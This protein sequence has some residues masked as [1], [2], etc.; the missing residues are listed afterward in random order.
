MDRMH[1]TRH[2]F[3]VDVEEWYHPLRFYRDTAAVETRRLRTGL[4]RITALLDERGV[5]GTFFWVADTA[6]AYPE[7]VR[8]L[9]DAGHETGCHSFAH[10][11]MVYDQTPEDF[12]A[13]TAR[14][15]DVLQDLTGQPVRAYRAPCFSVTSAS[16]WALDVLAELGV[17]LDSSVFPVKNWR[18][19]I[20]DHPRHPVTA[21]GGRLWEAPLSARTVG[22]FTFP[23]AG[24]AYF[25]I[26]PYRFTAANIRASAEPVVFYIH[27]WELD[28]EHPFVRIPWKP[29]ATHYVNLRRTEPRLRRLLA[30]FRFAPL[31]EVVAARRGA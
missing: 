17:T 6:L 23:A 28:P 22:P 16:L 9:A 13:E 29:C 30:D 2:A 5:R 10:D 12:R 18:Y 11:R 14:A 24:G 7:L 26:Y 21:A 15:L 20:P 4:D 8:A 19:G 1:E 25:R 27:P 3:T 31:G